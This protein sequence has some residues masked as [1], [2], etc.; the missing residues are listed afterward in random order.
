MKK[1]SRCRT[2]KSATEFNFKNKRLRTRQSACKKCTRQEVRSHYVNNKEYYLL[3]ARKRNKH[4]R[5]SIKK[6]LW[7]YLEDHPC[8]DCGEKDPIVMDFDHKRDKIA[9]ISSFIKGNYSLEKVKIEIQKCE[10][11]CA[12]CHRRKTARDF[13]WYKYGRQ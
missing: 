7:E 10:V 3:K 6:Y 4:N 8:V 12:N 9:A 13:K 11:R 2:E 5:E 1:C